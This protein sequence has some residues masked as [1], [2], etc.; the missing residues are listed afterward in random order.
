M[1]RQKAIRKEEL[2]LELHLKTFLKVGLVLPAESVSN[3]SRRR[4]SIV[5]SGIVSLP[6]FCEICGL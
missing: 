4:D 6:N 3:T 5:A 2:L 1:I